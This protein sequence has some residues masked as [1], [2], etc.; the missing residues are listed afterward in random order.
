VTEVVVNRDEVGISDW[1]GGKTK[2]VIVPPTIRGQTIHH[3]ISRAVKHICMIACISAAGESLTP[4]RITSQAPTLVQERLKKEGVRFGTD[5]ALRSNS[6]PYINAEIFFDYIR[7]VF[8]PN[9]AEHGTLNGFAQ[10]TGVLLMDNC[11][12]HVTDHIIGLLTETRVRV[13]SL[14]PRTTQSFQISDVTFFGPLKRGMAYELPFEDE[15][16][17][18]K[19]IMKVYRDFKKIMMERNIWE[20]FRTIGFEFEFDTEAESYRLLFN[21]E[22]LRQSEGFR[23]L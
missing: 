3:E 10:E 19:F 2:T 8:L 21:E 6:K 17:T 16:E 1:K 5:F 13:I 14:A 4:S 22:K 23:E 11:P 9:L 12:S 18:D 15:K 20:A 7:T